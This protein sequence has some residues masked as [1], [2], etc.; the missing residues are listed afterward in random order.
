REAAQD[1]DI[2]VFS[3][4]SPLGAAIVGKKAGEKT[5]Y[6]APNGK[7]ISVEI[8]EVKPFTGRAR[9][10]AGHARQRPRVPRRRLSHRLVDDPVA[11]GAQGGERRA[12][13]VEALG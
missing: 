10:P 13:L 11:R 1:V 8:H 5:S 12:P 9:P 2:E 3:E 7:S 6:V 4:S